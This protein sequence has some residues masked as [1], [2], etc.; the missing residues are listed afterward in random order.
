MPKNPSG[1]NWL[2]A[3]TRPVPAAEARFNALCPCRA[4]AY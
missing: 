2:R 1:N 3:D 4:S